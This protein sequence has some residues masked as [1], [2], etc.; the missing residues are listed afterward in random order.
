MGAAGLEVCT[1]AKSP[2]DFKAMSQEKVLGGKGEAK[3]PRSRNRSASVVGMWSASVRL[4]PAGPAHS[5]HSVLAPPGRPCAQAP[6]EPP[7]SSLNSPAGVI[8]RRFREGGAGGQMSS[9]RA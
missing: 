8:P 1:E 7:A 6:H 9:H 3:G 2:W 5:T 4:R